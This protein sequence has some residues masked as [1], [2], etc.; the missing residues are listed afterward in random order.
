MQ[1]ERTET[2]EKSLWGSHGSEARDGPLSCCRLRYTAS[3][4]ADVLQMCRRCVRQYSEC[5]GE[6]LRVQQQPWQPDGTHASGGSLAQVAL[7][8]G[9]LTSLGSSPGTRAQV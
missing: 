3:S 4:A 2:R 8:P 1:P 5:D 9:A 6:P 7:G